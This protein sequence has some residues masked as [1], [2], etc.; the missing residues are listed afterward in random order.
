[1]YL[2]Q[3]KQAIIVKIYIYGHKLY[4]LTPITVISHLYTQKGN[5]VVISFTCIPY[6]FLKFTNKIHPVRKQKL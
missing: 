6:L 1:M 2:V 4:F 5:S 3:G